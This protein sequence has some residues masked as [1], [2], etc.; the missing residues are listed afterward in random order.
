MIQ[1]GTVYLVGAGPGDPGLLTLRGLEILRAAEVVIYD[2]L[3]NNSLLSEARS[4]ARLIYVGKEAGRHA[5]SQGEINQLLVE[6]AKAG[7]SVCR[8]KG[9]DPFLFG[10][11]GE[12]AAYL[13]E[14]SIP[15]IIVPG[16]TSAIAAPAYAGIPITDRRFGSSVAIITGHKA[17][18]KEHDSV[19]WEWLAKG[20]DTLVV[21][22]GME[23]FKN[24]LG[25]G[26]VHFSECDSLFWQAT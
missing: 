16:V 14:H 20:A 22:M 4:D 15:F 5:L 26:V 11:G 9:G 6:E 23:P 13:R 8:L 7:H 19:K 24:A 17:A 25:L 12:E 1:T 10:R 3:A 18:D 2:R 21:L